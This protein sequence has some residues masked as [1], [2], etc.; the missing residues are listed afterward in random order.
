MSFLLNPNC[1]GTSGSVVRD[2]ENVPPGTAASARFFYIW[3]VQ[4]PQEGTTSIGVPM[5]DE[6]SN[7][8]SAVEDTKP[9]HISDIVVVPDGYGADEPLSV[10]GMARDPLERLLLEQANWFHDQA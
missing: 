3:R 8:N 6:K 2:R 5:S 1:P 7:P 4:C 10:L 9:G